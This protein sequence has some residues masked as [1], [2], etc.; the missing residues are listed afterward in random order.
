MHSEQVQ[1]SLL[2]AGNLKPAAA[3]S[4]PF[5]TGADGRVG[6]GASAVL[7]AAELVTGE[8]LSHATHWTAE[9]AF[10]TPQ[11][12][13]H[14]S[15]SSFI[16]RP[17]AAQLKAFTG[18]ASMRG[19]GLDVLLKV[20]AEGTGVVSNLKLLEDL[21]TGSVKLNVGKDDGGKTLTSADA[22]VSSALRRDT[23]TAE[24]EKLKTGRVSKSID[25]TSALISSIVGG[26]LSVALVL[27]AALFTSPLVLKTK[28]NPL[29]GTTGFACS[30]RATA[31]GDDRGGRGEGLTG[32]TEDAG[33]PS[34]WKLNRSLL[35]SL[36]IDLRAEKDALDVEAFALAATTVDKF[37]FIDF[38]VSFALTLFSSLASSCRGTSPISST[39]M[40][41]FVAGKG[42]LKSPEGRPFPLRLGLGFLATLLHSSSS[43]S[44]TWYWE[45][46]GLGEDFSKLAGGR[47][48]LLP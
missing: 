5:T 9:F 20:E 47:E 29:E 39:V 24:I 44:S 17:E 26:R 1:E 31:E 19:C 36:G 42:I 8:G 34:A 4:K 40:S 38:V 23:E 15:F 46:S 33:L 27:S 30:I 21:T 10:L 18:G 32:G 2:A 37:P 14:T 43:G 22:L 12:Q 6:L 7:L 28:L 41:E 11:K 3:K 13:V 48:R 25:F 45:F 35:G 16:F